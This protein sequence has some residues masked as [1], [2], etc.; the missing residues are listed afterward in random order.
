MAEQVNGKIE[1][2][3]TENENGANVDFS[4]N[5]SLVDLNYWIDQVKYLIVSGNAK[6]SS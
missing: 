2:T 3:I 1:I 5:M 4:T 6:I